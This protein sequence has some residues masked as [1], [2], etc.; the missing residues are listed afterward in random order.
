MDYKSKNFYEILGVRKSA[1]RDEIKKAYK[2]LVII[3]HPDKNKN[4]NSSKT[5]LEIQIAYETLIDDNKRKKYDS[6]DVMDNGSDIRKAFAYYYELVIEKCQEYEISDEDKENIIDIF[7][8]N[9]Y[10][11]E[12]E[13]GNMTAIHQKITEK[14]FP[15]ILKIVIKNVCRD[16]LISETETLEII[17]LFDINDYKYELENNNISIIYQKIADKII[18]YLPKFI[19]KRISNNYPFLGSTINFF[20]EWLI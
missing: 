5:F 8:P 17:N 6:F 11:T 7:N 2:K 3:Y 9:D 19:T 10:Q 16:Y 4:F 20:S 1:S 18:S 12:I 15:M 14:I 13:N